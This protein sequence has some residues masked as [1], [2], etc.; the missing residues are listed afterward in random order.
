[1]DLGWTSG[2][3]ED[4]D[5]GKWPDKESAFYFLYQTTNDDKP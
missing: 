5:I 1:M 3:A 2:Y 4:I